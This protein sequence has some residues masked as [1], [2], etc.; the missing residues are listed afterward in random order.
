MWTRDE[1]KKLVN[2]VRREARQKLLWKTYEEKDELD[3]RLKKIGLREQERLELEERLDEV[4]LRIRQIFKIP[5]EKLLQDK[6]EE[7]DWMKI[8]AR[9]MKMNHSATECMLHWRNLAHPS[10][11]K[12]PWT[13]VIYSSINIAP[14]TRVI[15]TSINIAPWTPVIYSIFIH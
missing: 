13:R 15:K 4:N 8:A 10:I 6:D 1:R 11:N 5:D 14:W 2:T 12:A 3:S 7:Y 9:D